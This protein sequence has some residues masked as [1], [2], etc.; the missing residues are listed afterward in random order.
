MLQALQLGG[1]VWGH[2]LN[3]PKITVKLSPFSLIT[4]K[5][6]DRKKTKEKQKFNKRKLKSSLKSTKYTPPPNALS[7][8]PKF[9]FSL[10]D[11]ADMQ[12]CTVKQESN[13]I[14]F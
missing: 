7:S 5:F 1:G 11:S 9:S 4:G 3:R 10:V 8:P 12:I 14:N 2:S 13:I 6:L